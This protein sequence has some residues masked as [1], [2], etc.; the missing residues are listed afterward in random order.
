MSQ[1]TPTENTPQEIVP[2][3]VPTVDLEET[4]SDNEAF[5]APSAEEHELNKTI[6]L[7]FK[8]HK[9]GTGD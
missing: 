7:P 2:A 6:M 4:E 1:T 3:V 9:F 5:A 8:D